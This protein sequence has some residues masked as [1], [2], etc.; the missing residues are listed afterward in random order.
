ML[1]E[2]DHCRNSAHIDDV[3]CN[4]DGSGLKCKRGCQTGWDGDACDEELPPGNGQNCK[5]YQDGNPGRCEQCAT[6]DYIADWDGTECRACDPIPGCQ[7][8]VCE[9]FIG[10]RCEE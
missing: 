3:T 6:N 7:H 4:Q 9:D 10:A 8:V 1:P 5:R 2:P